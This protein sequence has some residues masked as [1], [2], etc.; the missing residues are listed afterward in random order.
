MSTYAVKVYLT[1]EDIYNKLSD[2]DKK[3]F[4][5]AIITDVTREA[6]MSIG[7]TCI[8]VND[9]S[10]GNMQLDR[11]EVSKRVQDFINARTININGKRYL[12][13]DDKTVPHLMMKLVLSDKEYYDVDEFRSRT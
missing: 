7:I 5:K 9:C 2:E 10:E 13:V 1:A 3:R 4:N 11:K 8:L 12:P 6:D